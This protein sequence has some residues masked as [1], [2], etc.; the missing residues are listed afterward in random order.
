MQDPRSIRERQA[1]GL[2][3]GALLIC[4]VVF[5]IIS[6]C[7]YGVFGSDLAPDVITNYTVEALGKLVWPDLAQAAFF[8]I[9]L[10]VLIALLVSF[11]LHVRF[12]ERAESFCQ[13]AA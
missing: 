8:G 2:S 4:T 5:L 10:A 1:Q 3:A 13:V 7:S 12:F 11:P 6:I 9:R